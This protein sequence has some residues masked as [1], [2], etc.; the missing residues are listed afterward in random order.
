VTSVLRRAVAPFAAVTALVATLSA[1]GTGPSQVNTAA[2]V[3]DHVVSVDDV[4]ALVDKVAKEPAAR[5]L[6][7]SHKLDLVGSEAVSQLVTHQL[8]TE[9]ARE[10]NLQV[11]QEQLS[12]WREEN[13]L[14]QQLPTD[15]SV[16]AEQLVPMLVSRAR[17][18][19]AFAND[20][21][22]LAALAEKYLGRVN[23]KANLVQFPTSDLDKA[24]A[25]AEQVA[26]RPD[27]GPALMRAGASE[28]APPQLNVETGTEP[29]ALQLMAPNNSVILVNVPGTAEGAGSVAVVQV[30][31]TQIS[32]SAAETDLGSVDPSQLSQ[33]GRYVLRQTLLDEGIRVSPRYGEW[34]F[35]QMNVP[36]KSDS[37]PADML[38]LAKNND[39]S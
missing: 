20:T 9:V 15:G 3:G 35:A 28:Q 10:E 38:L 23:V 5:S 11:D 34:N 6:V 27:E 8:I 19:D 32:S 25:L 39:K 4:Q 24:K 33:Y 31:S 2:I 12:A 36:A 22:L 26:A 13:P 37:A 16:P 30:L 21:L 7:Q 14:E 1:C 18:F 29:I 17:G